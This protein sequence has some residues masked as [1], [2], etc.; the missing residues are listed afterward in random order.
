MTRD[1][2]AEIAAAERDLVDAWDAVRL[3]RDEYRLV[4]RRIGIAIDKARDAEVRLDLLLA[5]RA[6]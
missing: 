2:E 5:E 1:L 6:R 3:W 4:E